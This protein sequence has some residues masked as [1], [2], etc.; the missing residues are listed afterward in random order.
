[1]KRLLPCF[2]ALCLLLSGCSVQERV[3]ADVFMLRLTAAK[4]ITAEPL[5][6]EDGSCFCFVTFAGVRAALRLWETQD[7]ALAKI[8]V[9]APGDSDREKFAALCAQ[10]LRV[11]APNE[12]PQTLTQLLAAQTSVFR[13]AQG[14]TH[15]L[16]AAADA[17][18][19]FFSVADDLLAPTQPPSLTLRRET[20]PATE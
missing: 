2:A 1:M 11:Y 16:C 19:R 5:Y 9:S 3:N 13:Y 10:V 18:G 4:E 17:A 12:L 8:A 7:G 14:R 6:Y 20:L 15:R